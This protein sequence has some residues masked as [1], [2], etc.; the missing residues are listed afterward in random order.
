MGSL[1]NHKRIVIKI[2]S[3]SLTNGNGSL[4]L[5]ALS[6][7]TEMLSMLHFQDIEVILVSSGAVAAGSQELGLDTPP[8]T[9][10]L[11]QAAA[12]VGQSVLMHAYRNLF[13]FKNI[14]VAQ[15]LLTR[16]D[17]AIRSSYN[18]ALVTLNTLLER[19]I[20]P[21]INEND[22]VKT[23]D[24]S[25]GD[26]DL[27]ATLVSALVHADMLIILT[28]IDGIYDSNPKTNPNAIRIKKVEEVTSEIIA[29]S[30]G[31]GSILGS[32]GMLSKVLAAQKAL[33]LGV[34]VFIGKASNSTELTAILN[35]EGQGTYLGTSDKVRSQ[36]K[37]QWIAFSSEVKGAVTIDS[38]AVKALLYSGRSLLAVGIVAVQGTFKVNDVIEVYDE[39][40]KLIRKGI[41]QF[42]SDEVSQS[43][44]KGTTF[45]KEILK[46]S[47]LEVIHRD[48]WVTF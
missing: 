17:F 36:R 30:G 9:L 2:G 41:T 28:D 6:L 44:G 1:E 24:N 39:E 32:G 43:I 47:Q 42:S 16:R 15:V 25:F 40:F 23:T 5:V 13:S 37:L 19:K 46:K 48:N 35:G 33:T 18:N 22:T 34:P 3:S 29:K 20:I 31:T 4:N 21:V 26:N 14:K 7:Y 12:A 10:P 45:A 8:T 38:G 11:R 27:L